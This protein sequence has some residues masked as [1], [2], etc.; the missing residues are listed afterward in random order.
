MVQIFNQKCVRCYER[1]SVY[2]FRQCGHQCFYKQCF[3][4]KAD[5]DILKCVVCIT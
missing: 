3:Q 1:V 4:N 5:I 2:T